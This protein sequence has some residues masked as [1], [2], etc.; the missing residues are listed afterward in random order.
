VPLVKEIIQDIA[1][2]D[3][4]VNGLYR[5]KVDTLKLFE[6][7]SGV[8]NFVTVIQNA[9]MYA[10][11]DIRIDSAT[12]FKYL[13]DFSKL[14]AIK[15]DIIKICGALIRVVNDKFP[16]DL[17]MQIFFAFKFILIKAGPAVK[18]MIPQLQTTFLKAYND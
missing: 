15:S 3:I 1:V 16:C 4:N 8:K 13:I 6:K 11:L 2:E 7:A 18:T 12:C 5:K 14:E 9:I 10:S 17:K